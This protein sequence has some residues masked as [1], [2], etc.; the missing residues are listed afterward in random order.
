[1][2]IK[3]N[4]YFLILIVIILFLGILSFFKSDIRNLKNMYIQDVEKIFNDLDNLENMFIK[5]NI[6][7]METNILSKYSIKEIRDGYMNVKFRIK[8]LVDNINK[9]LSSG[10]LSRKYIVNLLNDLLGTVDNEFLQ[11]NIFSATDDI[12]IENIF[13][14]IDNCRFIANKYNLLKFNFGLSRV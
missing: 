1:M 4:K 2:N 8:S 11:N 3:V 7:Y 5:E 14:M 10:N 9:N 13:N 12:F 6:K